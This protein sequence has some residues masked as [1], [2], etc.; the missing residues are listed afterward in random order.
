MARQ[1]EK[2]IR[3]EVELGERSYPVVVGRGVRES[4]GDFL[5]PGQ[6]AMVI[7][8]T[9]VPE[10]L[11]P[12]LQERVVGTAVICDDEE[13]KSL[14]EVERLC[15][16]MAE[17]GVTRSDAVVSVGGGLVSDVAGFAAAVYHR[18][19]PVVH[20]PTTLLA[21]VDAAIGGK[22]GVNLRA[23]KNLVGA[24]WQPRAVLCDTSALD[25]LDEREMR[26]GLGEMAKYEFITRQ[27]L[28]EGPIEAR[29]AECIR[30]KGEIVAS[31]ERESGRRALLNYG[32]TLAH[33]LE[34]ETKFAIAHG[35]AVAA[36]IL[37]AAHLAERLGRI[38][39]SRVDLHHEIVRGRYGLPATIPHGV[40]IDA[41]L[42]LMAKDKKSRG[43]LTFVLD[44]PDGLEMVDGIAPEMVRGAFADLTARYGDPR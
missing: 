40:T 30:I 18:G 9:G 28:P 31:D 29:I 15:E 24:F 23:G 27:T 43:S 41:L 34:S 3:V 10:P 37:M 38:D 36:G 21:M 8:G 32:H 7:T 39:A 35:E 1:S 42:P 14:E 2:Q 25:T 19:I 22:T 17:A 26:C 33:A 5:E 4:L 12:R 11:R 44:G 16:A 13:H 20:L 6:R